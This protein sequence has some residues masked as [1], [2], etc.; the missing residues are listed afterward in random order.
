MG[1]AYAF[2]HAGYKIPSAKTRAYQ[3]TLPLLLNGP[4]YQ[5]FIY[6]FVIPLGLGLSHHLAFFRHQLFNPFLRPV[7]VMCCLDGRSILCR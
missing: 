5:S 6:I 2:Y 7:K 3:A 4:S 1:P